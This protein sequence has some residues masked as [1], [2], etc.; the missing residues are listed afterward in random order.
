MAPEETEHEMTTVVGIGASAGGLAA[1]RDLF[2]HLSDDTGM[3]FVVIVHLAP[4]HE[5]HLADLLQTECA[6]PIRQVDQTLALDENQVYVIPPGKNLSAVDT[7][8]RLSEL[9]PERRDRSPI[10]HFF[11]TLAATHDGHS[12]GVVLSGT[13]TDGTAG[14]AAIKEGG[15][16]TIVQD[17]DEAEY[18]GMPRSALDA[19]VVDLV[20]PIAGIADRI[21]VLAG[22]SGKV[23]DPQ[24]S[25]PVDDDEALRQIGGYI[26]SRTGHDIA[27]YKSS[28]VLR[29]IRRRMQL[30]QIPDFDRY[31]ELLRSEHHEAA[32]LFDDILISVTSFFRDPEVFDAIEERIVPALFATK[33][34]SD[35]VRVWS[36]GCAT[37]EEAYS[38]AIVLLEH[39]ATLADPPAIQIFASD[40]HETSLRRAR[41]GIYPATIAQDVA[42]ERLDEY[43]VADSGGYRIR[44]ALREIVVFAHHD[45]LRDPPF[46]HMDLIV[47]RNVLIYLR[48]DTQDIAA[49]VFH[50]ALEPG[51][52]LVLGTSE[53]FERSD[54]F[55]TIDKQHCLLRRR[56][57]ANT[58]PLLPVF[59]PIP[60]RIASTPARPAV[61]RRRDGY[62]AAH[63][64]LVERYAPPSILIDAEHRIVH[65]TEAAGRYLRHPGGEPTADVFQL[66]A[67]GLRL[68]LRTAVHAARAEGGTASSRPVSVR[69]DGID[70]RVVIR[71]VSSDD[72]ELDGF[73]LVLFDEVPVD[74]GPEVSTDVRATDVVGD[75]EAQLELTH[76]RLQ[77]V[78]DDYEVGQ[79]EMQTS[80]EELQS[81]N[82]ELR[83]TMEELETSKEEL[84][85]MNEELATLNQENRHKVEELGM[86]SSDLQN[87][88]AST[89]IATL[90]LDRHLRIV[91]FT[92]PVTDLFNVTPADR[93]RPLNDFTHRLQADDLAI[94]AQRVL[95]RLAPIE[96]EIESDDGRWLLTRLLPYR[97][98][99][100]RIEGVVITFVDVTRRFESELALRTSERRLRLALEASAMGT[101]TLTADGTVTADERTL[102]IVGAQTPPEQFLSW[103]EQRLGAADRERLAHALAT[104][105]RSTVQLE[106]ERDDGEAIVVE[107]HAT[108][109]ADDLADVIGTLQ[110][111]TEQ[112]GNIRS[113]ARQNDR[114]GL[115]SRAAEQLL[116]GDD[117]DSFIAEFFA[118]M[119]STLGLEIFERFDIDESGTSVLR[120]SAG[121]GRDQT[122][123]PALGTQLCD[124]AVAQRRIIVR[125][126]IGD[127]GDDAVAE[128]RAL[129]LHSYACVPLVSADAVIGALCFGTRTDRAIDDDLVEVIRTVADYLV[130][131]EQRR[132]NEERLRRLNVELEQTVSH[133]TSDLRR[134]EV[135]LNGLTASLVTAEQRERERIA[136]VLHD[137]LQQL[138]YSAQMHVGLAEDT[139]DP[140]RTGNESGAAD[141]RVHLVELGRSLD[142]AIA[143]ARSLTVDLAPQE[144]DESDFG[145]TV[146]WLADQMREMHGLTVD[147]S[148]PSPTV[149]ADK[150]TRTLLYRTV[151][152]LLFNVVKHAHTQRASI[153]VDDVDGFIVVVVADEGDGFE[154]DA[155]DDPALAGRG[156]VHIRHRIELMGGSVTVDASPGGGTT[157]RVRGPDRHVR[158]TD[159]LDSDLASAP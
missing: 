23:G 1:L 80:N 44:Q 14:L 29:R 116:R 97:S 35:V 151:R 69:L 128:A 66:V 134:R 152:E 50:Y 9:E 130:V 18:A 60:N 59:L 105:D 89:D 154:I 68:D 127:D 16:V 77:K 100:D 158:G 51:G 2:A 88:L 17:P 26:R 125:H 131:A 132:Y 62:G 96:R 156:L 123:A 148:M 146:Q 112:V 64:R 138:L 82:E 40:P 72:E 143:L 11:R 58:D 53:S 76:R 114:V 74:S 56:E 4:D 147:V 155:L 55:S 157:V 25:E 43:F 33:S 111:V 13:G 93:G 84:Q 73:V 32:L 31:I 135:Q 133:R 159:G 102:A 10:D 8:L 45:L 129:G 7:H 145:G 85:S 36:A 144:L 86:L 48:R 122:G 15:G 38:L 120:G 117:P 126:D 91:R 140:D 63:A 98:A 27:G 115:V 65:Y 21:R 150:D 94:D 19:G 106:L 137:D 104:L 153:T 5:S 90:F 124:E 57:V 52:Y 12:I 110:D 79:E 95:E 42:P 46:S 28:T 107:L 61:P 20:A 41:E 54:L 139:L 99:E 22:V 81:T 113:L 101:W 149:V 118:D 141:A 37:G 71:A 83:S 119:S 67:D 3:S 39:A 87:L 70:R 24:D 109:V 49:S 75:L 92:A 142:E 30:H 6:M 34:G 78:I 103:L 108:A 136:Q 47:C 121:T